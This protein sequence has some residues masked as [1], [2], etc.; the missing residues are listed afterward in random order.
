MFKSLLL[1]ALSMMVM[2]PTAMSISD[3]SVQQSVVSEDET[4]HGYTYHAYTEGDKHIIEY[5]SHELG[6]KTNQLFVAPNGYSYKMTIDEAMCT[7]IAEQMQFQGDDLQ[8]ILISRGYLLNGLHIKKDQEEVMF[9][10]DGTIEMMAY[11][12]GYVVNGVDE[13]GYEYLKLDDVQTS[14]TLNAVIDLKIKDNIILRFVGHDVDIN[15]ITGS[16]FLDFKVH[17][18]SNPRVKAHVQFTCDVD[19]TF[20]YEGPEIY[21]EFGFETDTKI[22]HKDD[23]KGEDGWYC[24]YELSLLLNDTFNLG[25]LPT[26]N[27][28]AYGIDVI[29]PDRP[30]TFKARL[31]FTAGGVDYVYYSKPVELNIFTM[32]VSIDGY[33]DRS[34]VQRGAEYEFE[35]DHSMIEY[36][37]FNLLQLSL[38]AMPVRLMDDTLGHELYGDKTL[39]DVG[40]DGHYYYEPSQKE[41]DLYD[42][43]KMDELA[44]MP[45]DG[46]YLIWDKDSQ[47]YINFDSIEFLKY[48]LDKPEC[49]ALTADEY[50]AMFKT[51]QSLPYAGKWYFSTIFTAYFTHR[52][53]TS[54]STIYFQD[55]SQ[56]LDV[57]DATPEDL[58]V[59]I[60]LNVPNAFNMVKNAGQIQI[61]PSLTKEFEEKSFYYEWSMSKSGIVEISETA[62]LYDGVITVNPINAGTVTLT[63]KCESQYFTE[64]KQEITIHVLDSVYGNAKLVIPNEFHYSGQDLTAFID[65]RGVTDFINLNIDWEVTDKNGNPLDE[66]KYTV[67]KNA[68]LTLK[69]PSSNDYTIKAFFEGVEVGSVSFEVRKVNMNLFLAHNIW[70]IILITAGFVVLLIFINKLTKRGKTTV[71]FIERVYDV[72]SNCLADEKLTKFELKKIKSELSRCINRVED[73]NIDSFNQYEK[74]LRYLKKSSFD[75]KKLFNEWESLPESD[76]SVYIER[77]DKD[78]SKALMVAKEIENAR[79]IIDE[80][81]A[82]ANKHNFE[83]LKEE[84]K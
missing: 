56:T 13:K 48:S 53:G 42:Q 67:N 61:E 68:S 73:L 84:K 37:Q 35:I 26:H 9:Y 41:K 71:Q 80:Y 70:W 8:G 24:S 45:F 47:S 32:P 14:V 7:E 27:S 16:D 44:E 5:D 59:N 6:P 54:S 46:T 30:T 19:P 76:R 52:F 66:T 22:P 55:E 81:H 77:L 28:T 65:I 21:N 18:T 79:Q 1:S 49:E 60:S 25:E 12:I 82:N 34:S 39:P 72:F 75:A 78:L 2:T 74:V 64:I 15:P 57:I 17:Y 38:V 50:E 10:L 36:T 20:F 11:A 83:V 33:S 31:S 40:Q 23:V 3:P 43:G 51:K 29:V 63:V 58:D 4:L 62:D 69:S